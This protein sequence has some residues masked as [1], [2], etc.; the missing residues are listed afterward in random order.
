MQ[1][2]TGI[3]FIE[4]KIV[5]KSFEDFK[6]LAIEII[7][8]KE[9]EVIPIT[10]EEIKFYEEQKECNVCTKEFCYDANKE[11]EFKLY[12]KVRDHCHYA[13]KFRGAA[14]NICNLRYKVPKEIPVVFHNGST[15]EYHFMIKQLAEEFKGQFEYLG[16]NTEK[17]IT[18]SIIIKKEHDNCK[19]STCKLKFMIAID[20]RTFKLKFIDSYRFTQSKLA[21]LT[22]NL[23][24]ISDKERKSCMER[25]KIKSECDLIG[26]RNNRLAYK[27]KECRKRCSKL[28]NEA[29]RNF[30]IRYQF[31]NGDHN[32]F[33]LL[34]GK[35]VYPYEYM[36]N[37]EKFNET[38]IP[39]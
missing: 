22:D 2:K 37:W 9:Q 11:N 8:C 6:E 13:G 14:H 20:L 32:K 10:D 35:G 36:D 5:L 33:A 3:I 28:I 7:N 12:H 15:Y 19:T 34:L 27:C 18:F 25:K 1:Q 29:V 17:Y 38:S 26:F 21:G 24:G 4:E 39:P 16:E 30:P 31:C 23:S